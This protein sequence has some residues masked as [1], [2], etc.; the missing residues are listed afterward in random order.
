MV[1]ARIAPRR[2]HP[3][4]RSRHCAERYRGLESDEV[5]LPQLLDDSLERCVRVRI[6]RQLEEASPALA[7][8]EAEVGIVAPAALKPDS[9]N[10]EAILPDPALEV[11]PGHLRP[12]KVAVTSQASHTHDQDDGSPGLTGQ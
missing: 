9:I 10:E 7:G 5:L 12:R 8:K 4:R 1:K 3:Q 11:C 6:G 2:A